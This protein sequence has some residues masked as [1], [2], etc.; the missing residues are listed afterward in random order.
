MKRSS[1]FFVSPI[2]S[3]SLSRCL[4]AIFTRWCRWQWWWR[5]SSINDNNEIT[6]LSP[7]F[8][9]FYYQHHYHRVWLQRVVLILCIIFILNIFSSWL[10]K[11]NVWW[12]QRQHY[13]LLLVESFIRI[14]KNWWGLVM[15][16][17]RRSKV[18]TLQVPKNEF[19]FRIIMTTWNIQKLV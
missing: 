3:L 10:S 7:L 1:K 13:Y 15:E 2:F 11:I 12:W 9:S 14:K 17:G 5:Y 19:V 8:L 16:K 18:E 6:S 4:F